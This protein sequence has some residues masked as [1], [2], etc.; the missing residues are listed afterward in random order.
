MRFTD[1]AWG[2]LFIPLIVGLILSWRHF[3][4]MARVRK[5]IAFTIRFLMAGAVV[6]ALMGPQ[7]YR[8]NKGTAV[9][10]VMDRSD[11]VAEADRRVAEEFVDRAM[12][13]LGPDDAAGVVT[14]GAQAVV[15]AIPGGKRPLGRLMSVVDSSG[16]DLAAAIRLAAASFPDGKARRIVVL[17][18]GNETR[19][20]AARAAEAAAIEGVDVDYVA[21]GTVQRRVEASVLELQAPS[22]R[23]ADQPFELRALV[24]SSTEQRGVLIIDRNG[25]VVAEIPVELPAGKSS[26]V[27]SQLLDEPG[28]YRYRASLAVPE[29]TD[30]RNNVGA[31][32]VN[33]RG[34]P[35]LLLLQGDASQ[36]ELADALRKQGLI[37]DLY[38]PEG[39][40]ARAEDLQPYDAVILND[41]NAYYVAEYQMNMLRAAVNDTGIG[42]AMIGGE[43]SFLPGGWYGTPVAEALPVDLDIRQRKSFPSTTVLIVIDTSGSM[44]MKEDG[45]E[46][47]KLAIKAA[48]MTAELLSPRDRIGVAGSTDDIVYVAPIQDLTNKQAVISNIRKLRP[49]GG[50]VYAEPSM[51]FADQ[52]LRKEDTKVRH[53][54]FLA[55]GADT[56]MYGNS[57]AIVSQMYRDKITTTVVA[58][59]GGKDERF[60][61]QLAK[62]GGGLYYLADKASKLPQIFTQ[63]VAVMSRSAIEEGAFYPEVAFGEEILSG[64]DP[65]SIPALYAYCLTDLKP[66]ARLGMK[67]PKD[68]PILATWQYGLGTSLAFTSDAKSQWAS[69]WV[70]WDGFAQFWAQAVRAISRRATR[71]DYQ[72]QVSPVGGRGEITVHAYDRLGNPLVSNDTTVRVST[73]SGE[74]RDVKLTQEA[75]G[76]FTGW[77]DAEQLGSYIVT[78]AEQDAD[79][80]S[81]VSSSGFSIPYPP[82][83]QYQATNFPL[84][85]GIAGVTGGAAITDPLDAL[86]AVPDPGVSIEDL[87]L[88]FLLAAAVMLPVDVGV[89][90]IALPLTEMIATVVAWMKRKPAQEPSEAD[91]RIA[92]LRKAKLAATDSDPAEARGKTVILKPTERKPREQTRKPAATGATASKLLEAKRKRRESDEE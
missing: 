16:S 78:V 3:H 33:V 80:E 84:L 59:G 46:K 28:F 21:L 62:A 86:R 63:D 1:P 10:F 27:I 39:M 67:S 15:E 70:P 18:D 87:W 37:V 31:A 42:L 5:G 2:L 52:E 38:G 58:I 41:L 4:G 92:R 82:E 65:G 6:I 71:N 91:E 43:D 51:R 74:T 19:G 66:L 68:D 12:R 88:Y 44:A 76:V 13:S 30:N 11:S 53:L 77:F 85:E 81:R 75:P 72:V 14:F 34:R 56:D 79:G 24:E 22:E 7:S 29:D 26:I 90:R 60:L 89:R 32:F 40:P 64:I 9:I 47:Y 48:V 73:P 49:G 69:L 25:V 20:D 8:E 23:R 54:I 61:Q 57:L 17:T 83:Y 36:T 50:G 45:I 35:K 55:D